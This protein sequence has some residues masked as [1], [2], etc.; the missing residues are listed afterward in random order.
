MPFLFK[1]SC[2]K[3]PDFFRPEAFLAI[4]FNTVYEDT[5]CKSVKCP[6]EGDICHCHLSLGVFGP[7]VVFLLAE[8]FKFRRLLRSLFT[9]VYN[10]E[11]QRGRRAGWVRHTL[12]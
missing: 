9:I 10:W 4:V 6:L 5:Q 3:N 2:L 12:K 1:N 7:A 11:S 8:A